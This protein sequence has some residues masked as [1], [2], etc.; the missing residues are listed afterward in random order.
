M[1]VGSNGWPVSTPMMLPFDGRFAAWIAVATILIVT[2]GPDTVLIIR[3]AL[4]AGSRAASLSAAGVGL[5]SAVWAA[6]SVLG[7]AVLLE[8]SDLAFTAFKFAGAAYLIYLGFRSIVGTF[9]PPAAAAPVSDL[10]KPMGMS[11]STAFVQGLL[12]NL[13]N[14]KAGAIFVTVMPQ[15]IQPGD[16]ITRLILMVVGYDAIVIAWLCIYAVVVSRAQRGRIGARLQKGIERL[17]GTVMIGLGVRL[18]FERR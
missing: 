8:S 14:P 2:P 18:A 10:T 3:N 15:F 16:S 4:R 6:A 11:A 17:T 7:V 5:G 9:R 13:L 12:N 1:T